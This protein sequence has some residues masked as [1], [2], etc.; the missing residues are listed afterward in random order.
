MALGM[1]R[2]LM[3]AVARPR[4]VHR[5]AGHADVHLAALRHVPEKYHGLAAHL[6]ALCGL[7]NGV[8]Q[9]ELQFETGTIQVDYDPEQLSE[10]A[11]LAFL[12][13][14]TAFVLHHR[15][16]LARIGEDDDALT[17]LKAE[18]RGK[19]AEWDIA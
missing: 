12:E 3:K 13:Q 16:T 14:L 5:E 9:A 11:L 4:V 7:L 10:K 19:M 2:F 17:S 1:G 8:E 6:P 15:K 18:L